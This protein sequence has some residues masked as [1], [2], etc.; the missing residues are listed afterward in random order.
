ML[1]EYDVKFCGVYYLF[2]TPIYLALY[3]N[4]NSSNDAVW[5]TRSHVFL[6]RNAQFSAL[7]LALLLSV[8]M[9]MMHGSEHVLR[10][11]TSLDGPVLIHVHLRPFHLTDQTLKPPYQ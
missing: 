8:L 10:S 11:H 5:T 4:M 2:L 3:L 6:H 9:S 7:L 1:C